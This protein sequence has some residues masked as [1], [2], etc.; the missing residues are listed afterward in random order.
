MRSQEGYAEMGSNEYF[1]RL[2]EYDRWANRETIASLRAAAAPPGRAVRLISHI[3]A[4]KWLWLDRLQPG[5]RSLPVWPDLALEQLESEAE[6][7]DDAWQRYLDQLTAETLVQ[8]ITYTN[9]K[10]EQWSSAAHDILHHVVMHSAYHRGQVAA[11]LRAS[12]STPAYTDFIHA[13]RQGILAGS[14]YE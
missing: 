8:E 12:N 5:T 10:E 7:A 14:S 13:A 3:I 2:F 11:E 6:L 9:S 4:A 1:N